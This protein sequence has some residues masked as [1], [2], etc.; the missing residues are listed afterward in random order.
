MG[1]FRIKR[2]RSNAWVIQELKFTMFWWTLWRYE[3]RFDAER[4]AR[5]L[6]EAGHYEVPHSKTLRFMYEFDDNFAETL[7]DYTAR[8]FNDRYH[9]TQQETMKP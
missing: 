4:N 5:A 3:K 7:A 6:R 8:W 2:T 9:G 1:K